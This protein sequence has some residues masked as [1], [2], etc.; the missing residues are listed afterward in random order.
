MS[1]S[2]ITKAALQQFIMAGAH[3]K[4]LI[5]TGDP[6]GDVYAAKVAETLLGEDKNIKL[7]GLG[8][9]KL[10]D[11][12]V[13]LLANLVDEALIGFYE[14]FKKRGRFRRIFRDIAQAFLL[15]EKP[16]LVL[17]VD[18]YGFNIH[19]AG[20]A[21]ELNIPVL[22][23]VSPK[24]WAWHY[25]RIKKIGERVDRMLVI[26]PFEEEL[27]RKEGIEVT[28]VGNPIPDIVHPAPDKK[29]IYEEF[30]LREE[31]P[32]V[33]LL[34]GS[35]FQE[36][37]NLLPPML[38][39]AKKMKGGRGTRF[40]LV[41]AENI[42]FSY[43]EKRFDL[44]AVNCT[45]ARDGD[46]RLRSIMAFALVS[47]GTATLEN[48]YLGVPMIIM[49]RVSFPSY[50]LARLLVK[51]KYV[52]L[53]NIIASGKIVPEFIQARVPTSKIARIA[54]EWVRNPSCLAEIKEGL[55]LVREKIG[56]CGATRR[57]AGI[58]KD[59]VYE[60]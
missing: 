59:M 21:R 36:I 16:D 20:K 23:Y 2:G 40:V 3:K 29:K 49:Y 18:F 35:R 54:S 26:F 17:L 52:G 22:Y 24:V 7:Y 56:G 50:I 28:Y 8:G 37:D 31:E 4:I 53:P 19:V 27:Y 44:A 60:N 9:K 39:I 33:G 34:P 46:Y 47:A 5:V 45:I 1:R 32:V 42:P 41:L 14:A 6:S 43:V 58:V 12:G 30:N 51:V 57:V 48:A 25:G 10:E 55:S 13:T 11:A 38:D 15:R